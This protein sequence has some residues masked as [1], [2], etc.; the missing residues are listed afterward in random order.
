MSLNEDPDAGNREDLDVAWLQWS[1]GESDRNVA[2]RQSTMATR[3]VVDDEGPAAG[4]R[5]QD[6]THVACRADLDR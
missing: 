6:P 4:Q 1:I 3:E 2:D 5:G